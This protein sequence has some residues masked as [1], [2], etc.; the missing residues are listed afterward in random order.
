[1]ENIKLNRA[2]ILSGEGEIGTF[3]R[4][5]GKPTMAAINRLI[6]KERAGGDRWVNVFVPAGEGYEDDTYIDLFT[7][8]F[9]TI[10]QSDIDS[11]RA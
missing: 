9:R 8:D 1:M 6:I 5:T 3:K 2:I 10:K 4:Y 11:E 7:G